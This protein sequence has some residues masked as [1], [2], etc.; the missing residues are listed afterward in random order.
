MLGEFIAQ[1]EVY[2]WDCLDNM[3]D[4]PEDISTFRTR[5][6]IPGQEYDEAKTTTVYN[7]DLVRIENQ[8]QA[9]EE[10]L[11]VMLS[12]IFPIGSIYTNASDD[13]N[14]A[15]LIGVGTW[16]L[17]AEGK[18]LVGI[19]T[20]DTDFDTLGETGGSKQHLHTLSNDGYALITLGT[21]GQYFGKRVNTANSWTDTH[22]GD[23][24]TVSPGTSLSTGIEL[25]GSTDST[26][27]LPPYQ[28]V[29]MWERTA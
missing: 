15:T 16:E 13:T 27:A 19:D 12:N 8:L 24:S 23:G 5:E 29:Y 14:P 22:A 17:I 3:D 10:T 18:F 25:D 9:V 28:V 21:A 2:S 20:A 1:I 11:G 26:E 7:E 6:N 4:Y